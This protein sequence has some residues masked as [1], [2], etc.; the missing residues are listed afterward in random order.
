ML[1]SQGKFPPFLKTIW[2][3]GVLLVRC[4]TGLSAMFST[5]KCYRWFES[6]RPGC[7]KSGNQALRNK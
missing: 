7:A 6:I 4:V 1:K 2:L 3:Q 5:E